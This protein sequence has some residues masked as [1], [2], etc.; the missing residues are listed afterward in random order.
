MDTF[1]NNKPTA[2]KKKAG[3]TPAEDAREFFDRNGFYFDAIGELIKQGIPKEAIN[4]E[5]EKF[6]SYWTE[7]T[8]SGRMQRWETQK[9][10]EV[11]RRLRTWLM[12]TQKFNSFSQNKKTGI[13]L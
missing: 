6:I 2:I 8:K 4:T 13:V 7:P 12:N 3:N 1:L 5:F 10:F 9:T 11:K